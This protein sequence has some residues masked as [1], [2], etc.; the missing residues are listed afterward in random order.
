[1]IVDDT[2]N[3]SDSLANIIN[4]FKDK[5]NISTNKIMDGDLSVKEFK[6]RNKDKGG[7]NINLIF[8]DLNMIKMNGDEATILV[9]NL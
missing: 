8:M 1:M 3:N 6:K 9:N 5:Y 2:K 7:W 4:L